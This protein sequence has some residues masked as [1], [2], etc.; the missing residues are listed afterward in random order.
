MDESPEGRREH[1]RVLF[2][3]R[4]F[5]A[6]FL[7]F[8][9]LFV[10]Y[11][12]LGSTGPGFVL[13]AFSQRQK[14]VAVTLARGS[15]LDRHGVPL[16][17]PTWGTALVR[18][19]A[20]DED[21]APVKVARS[22]TAAQIEKA[23]SEAGESGLLIVP[24]E[25]RYG[26]GSLACH[27]VGHVRP[28]AYM[29]SRDNVGESGL[30][31]TFQTTL[32][33]G[34]PAW[35]GVVVTAEGEGVPGT[36]LR[37]APPSQAPEDLNTTID[38]AAQLVVE[39]ELDSAGVSRG[40]VVVLDSRTSEVLAMAS[41]PEF[42][43]NR[44]ELSLASG[45]APFVNRAI[46]AFTPGSVFK[47]VIVGLALERGYVSQDETFT[48]T[49]E[50]QI[51]DRT[52]ACGSTGRGHGVVTVREAL[53]HSCNSALIEMGLRIPA[54]VLLEFIL[55]CGFGSTTGLPLD[56]EA[57]GV[58]PTGYSL[59]AG[60]IANTCIG[61]GRLSVTPVQVAAFFAAIASDGVYRTPKLL[62]GGDDG[63][64]TRLFSTQTAALLQEALLLG[65]RE[66]T[67]KQAWVHAIGSAGKTGT[68]ETGRPS[69]A[70]HAWFC[71]FS[72]VIAPK[73]VIA[74]FVEEGG[75]GPSVAAPVFREISTHLLDTHAAT[76]P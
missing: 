32:A 35:S 18:F 22:L 49:G 56:D 67:G 33:G 19:P 43:Q 13:P 4:A 31:K 8:V 55:E 70:T 73:Y 24:E 26:P 39:E 28:N 10:R 12:I 34:V 30:E 57:S 5:T 38:A 37:I 3:K 76:A 60:D 59:Y 66:G 20:V 7:F 45:D 27:V 44:P 53:A 52:V 72:P 6:A 15:I 68:A 41:R 62:P 61:Q 51:G 47:P 74:V 46:A 64:E 16:H 25:I 69:G 54:P 9:G 14:S 29:D 42:D 2:L 1:E 71:G 75:D 40:A 17:C 50:V 36:G 58:T 23:L 65:A 11:Q 21:E 63:H 48:C